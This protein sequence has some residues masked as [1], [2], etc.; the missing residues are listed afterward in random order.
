MEFY[1]KYAMLFYGNT[2]MNVGEVGLDVRNVIKLGN[3]KFNVIK[4]GKI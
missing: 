3:V 2:K 1:N 4:F